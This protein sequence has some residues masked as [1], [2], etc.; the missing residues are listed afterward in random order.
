MNIFGENNIHM[1]AKTS[2]TSHFIYLM[3]IQSLHVHIPVHNTVQCTVMWEKEINFSRTI[4]KVLQTQEGK[5]QNK[6]QL[7]G[8]VT[9][10]I[11]TD[12]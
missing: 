5:E 11:R 3:P 10:C 2:M 1:E 7:T 4:K 6:E 8:L 9:F 12:F